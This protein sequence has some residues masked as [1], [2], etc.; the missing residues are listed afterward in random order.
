MHGIFRRRYPNN[1]DAV[2]ADAWMGEVVLKNTTLFYAIRNEDAFLVGLLSTTPWLPNDIEFQVIVT[3]AELGKA[4]RTLP[5]LRTS[6]DWAKY[7]KAVRWRFQSDTHNDI[8]PLMRRIGATEME[9][10]YKM[11]L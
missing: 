5:L 11:E 7:R 10:R 1:Y 8:G 6:I 9:P 3:A 4:W 2:S